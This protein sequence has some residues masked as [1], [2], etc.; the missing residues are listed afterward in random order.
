MSEDEAIPGKR[1]PRYSMTG[2]LLK[3]GLESRWMLEL[4]AY[5]GS[6][7]WLR[8][9][10]KGD[11]HPVIVFPG[12]LTSSFATGP[13]RRFLS[14]LGYQVHDWGF[15]RNLHYNA[16]LEARMEEM[17]EKR[18][19]ESGRKVSLLGWSLGGIYARE[20]AR[21]KPEMVRNVI[22]LGSPITG[23]K[24][25]TIAGPIFQLL[26]KELDP[27]RLEKIETLKI[28]PPVP[29]SVL[30]SA[31]DGVVHWHGAQQHEGKMS[32][33][34]HVPSSHMGM[35]SNPLVLYVIADRVRQAEDSWKPFNTTGPGRLLYRHPGNTR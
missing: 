13:L 9:L 8:N 14:D 2:K 15:G 16:E 12:F 20:I 29:N 25:V 4:A 10:P 11:G 27:K 24:H 22:S 32:E 6:R 33:N 17:V 23:S 26:N 30:F 31:S 7:S 35:G 21:A 5:Y 1:E 18:F 28:P 34:I 19:T 3:I